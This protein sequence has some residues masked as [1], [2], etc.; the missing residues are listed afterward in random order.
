MTVVDHLRDRRMLRVTFDDGTQAHYPYP[1]LRDNCPSAWHPET[2]ER[3]HDLLAIPPG[4]AARDA[5]IEDGHLA[6]AWEGEELVSRFP[7]A[8]LAEHAPGRPFADPADRPPHIWRAAGMSRQL[9]PRADAGALMRDDAALSRWLAEARATG[10][11]LVDGLA[12]DPEAGMAVARRIG[13]LRETNFGTVFEVKSKPN[14]NN[15][16]YTAVALPLHTDLPNQELPPGY[17]FLHCLAN[18]AV[19][20]GSVFADGFAIAAD[21]R[22]NDPDAFALLSTQSIP[23]R[24]HDGEFDIRRRQRVIT[25]DENGAVTEV[26]WNAHL[27]DMFDMPAETVE[28]YYMAYRAFMAA[29]R[30]PVYR[31][32]FA[33]KPGEMVV[34]DNRRVLHGRAAFDPATGHRHLRGFYVDRGEFDSRIR[35]LARTAA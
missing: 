4:L 15:L 25:L 16:A 13:F 28:A 17:Q 35:V 22:A 2:Q 12:D 7:L 34:F 30:D 20:G 5:A 21:L 29:L 27:A 23:F 6:V 31:I 10:L 8:W 14:P 9:M 1:W 3:M 18:E 24:F 33:L 32:E 19:G 26:C 11:A